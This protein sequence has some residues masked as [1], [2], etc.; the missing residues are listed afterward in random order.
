MDLAE[1]HRRHIDHWLHDCGYE[2]RR[3]LAEVCRANERLGR[4]YD[5]MAPGLSQYIHDAIMANCQRA[6][7]SGQAN[8]SAQH[9][10]Q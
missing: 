8:P 5:D 3:A 2:T 7:A 6:T 4:N 10:R 9:A 1:Q